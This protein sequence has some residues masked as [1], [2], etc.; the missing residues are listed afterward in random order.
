MTETVASSCPDCYSRSVGYPCVYNITCS[1]CRT[2][3]ALAEPCKLIRKS[4]VDSMERSWGEVKDWKGEPHCGCGKQCD[5]LKNMR[6][7][8][9]NLEARRVENLSKGRVRN[10]FRSVPWQAQNS[11]SRVVVD[12]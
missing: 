8:N 6:D 10:G 5:R 12:D 7:A 9:E 11:R 2:A 1:E 3:L 4:M